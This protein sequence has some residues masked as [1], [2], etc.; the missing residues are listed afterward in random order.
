MNPEAVAVAAIPQEDDKAEFSLRTMLEGEA[1]PTP[2]DTDQVKKE[3]EAHAKV[4]ASLTETPA[5]SETS[6]VPEGKTD[7]DTA[8]KESQDDTDDDATVAPKADKPVSKHEREKFKLREARNK[9]REEKEAVQKELA[10]LKTEYAVDPEPVEEDPNAAAIYKARMQERINLSKVRF[11]ER[12][13]GEALMAEKFTNSD[14]PWSEIEVQ[15][16]SGEVKSIQLLSR[17]SQATDPFAEAFNILE[18]QELFDQY[19]TT[20]LT[21]IIVKALEEE[22][23]AMEKRI[24]AKYN[25]PISD[26]GKATVT[27]GRV[28]GQ[29]EMGKKPEEEV[30]VLKTMFGK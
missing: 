15:A 18:E 20:S 13:G 22:E 16:K 17:A 23:E 26:I 24:L 25:K 29:S 3:A 9:E 21:R 10:A 8:P 14:S 19:H 2:V 12:E 4:T 5:K 1:L 11:L 6:P 7:T 28:S 30:S 27:L